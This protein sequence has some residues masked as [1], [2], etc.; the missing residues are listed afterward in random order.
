MATEE[1]V[2]LLVTAVQLSSVWPGRP[3]SLAPYRVAFITTATKTT[4]MLRFSSP[5]ARCPTRSG[6][7]W[8][9]QIN[10]VLGFKTPEFCFTEKKH[11]FTITWLRVV[12]NTCMFSPIVHFLFLFLHVVPFCIPRLASNFGLSV[13]ALSTPQCLHA[14]SDCRRAYMV[15]RNLWR[16][17]VKNGTSLR[18]TNT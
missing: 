6:S 18:I 13:Q 15:F 10:P 7:K 12:T 5:A 3:H 11:F 16:N 4:L 8:L 2:S 14:H 1:P 9:P 17:K